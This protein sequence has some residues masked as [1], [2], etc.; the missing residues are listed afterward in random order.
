MPRESEKSRQLC[1]SCMHLTFKSLRFPLHGCGFCDSLIRLYKDLT[2][3]QCLHPLVF[4]ILLE[5]SSSIVDLGVARI[6]TTVTIGTSEINRLVKTFLSN[7]NCNS[8][9]IIGLGTE[10]AQKSS[11]KKK[12][13]LLQLCDGR[14]C[15]IVQLSSHG[16]ALPRSLFNFLNLPDY[17]FV[18]IG[19]KKPLKMLE[20]EFGLTCKNAVEIGPPTRNLMTLEMTHLKHMMGNI[21]R[22][23]LTS[24]IFDDWGANLNENQIKLAVS[25]A[26]LAF[27][28]GN[29]LLHY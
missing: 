7:N 2:Y 16:L 8:K 4:P 28:M 3:L 24:T 15:L 26:Y 17:T 18:V 25:N 6:E 29:N 9:K 1:L 5:M 22:N 23:E 19:I 21:V 20:S 27:G 10:Q 13:V 12:T 14:Y 11:N